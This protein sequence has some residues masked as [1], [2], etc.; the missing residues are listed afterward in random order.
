MASYEQKRREN[1]LRN[2]AFMDQVGMSSAKLAARTAI[3]DE[4][5]KAT[6]KARRQEVVSKRALELSKLPRRKSQQSSGEHAQDCHSDKA[7]S[8]DSEHEEMAS[9]E[10][11]RRENILRN[12][13]FMDQVGMSSAKLAARTAISDEF[14]KATVKARRQEVV[15]KRALELSKL[16]RRKSR[17]ISGEKV[18]DGRSQAL[19]YSMELLY[20]KTRRQTCGSTFVDALDDD[21]KRILKTMMKTP[22]TCAKG[23]AFAHDDNLDYS[24]DFVDNVKAVPFEIR[25]MAFLPRADRVVLAC[26]DKEGYV[27]FWSDKVNYANGESID[28]S[29]AMYRPHGFP[30]SQLI[31]PDSTRLISS[32]Y[33]GTVREFDLWTSQTS[34][35]SETETG[36]SVTSLAGSA[37]SQFYY[38][39]CADGT[40]RVVDRRARRLQS[41]SYALHEMRINTLDQHPSLD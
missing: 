24:L 31:F 40:L 39:G 27:S 38:A 33:D 35:V 26:G 10:Q 22:D 6:V 8:S 17:R 20:M 36:Y 2:L 16:P 4:F 1:I 11:K 25:A 7:E 12:L 28:S 15:S 3:S 41:I 5:A 29:V 14:A 37:N 18:N 34:L 30:I 13:A 21:G 32:S 19:D 23:K 9:Y